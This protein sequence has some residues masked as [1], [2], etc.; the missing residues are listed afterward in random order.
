MYDGFVTENFELRTGVTQGS[1]L[2]PTLYLLQHLTCQ[3]AT[4]FAADTAI[5]SSNEITRIAFKDLKT[6]LWICGD[7]VEKLAN[8]CE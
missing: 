6:Y 8:T 2:G 7:M 1:V 3:Y 5:L 4:I